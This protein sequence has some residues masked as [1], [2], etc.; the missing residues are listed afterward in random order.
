MLVCTAPGRCKGVAFG[1]HEPAVQ[2]ARGVSREARRRS[3][4]H[5][6]LSQRDHHRLVLMNDRLLFLTV[7]EAWMCRVRALGRFGV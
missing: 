7:L 3:E 2:V 6:H 4:G 5:M 1:Q